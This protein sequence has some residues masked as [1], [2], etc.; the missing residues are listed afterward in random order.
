MMANEK[1]FT[2]KASDYAASRP[3]YAAAAID[4]IVSKMLKEGGLVAD[5]GSG[6]GIFSKEFLLRGYEVFAVGPNEAMRL[7]AEK[8]YGQNALFHSVAATAESTGLP[9]GSISLVTAAS[10]FHWFDVPRFYEECRRIL[11]SD[12]IV[13]ILANARIYD[14]FTEKQHQICRQYCPGYTSLTHGV[15][16]MLRDAEAFF[17]GAFCV[18]RFDY[19]L[20]FTK[21]KFIARSLSSSYAPEKGTADCEGYAQALRS[22]LDDTYPDDEIIIANETVMLW[23]ALCQENGLQ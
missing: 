18:E 13:C 19:P 17:K 12:G 4:R 6:T 16:K 2:A 1:V 22:L 9:A 5:V 15:E 21:Q 8:L 11:K 10:A 7:E 20:H 3:S 23:G 14:S